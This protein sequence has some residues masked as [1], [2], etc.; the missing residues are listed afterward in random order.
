MATAA[1]PDF[2][3]LQEELRQ[4]RADLSKISE[5]LGGLARHGAADAAGKAQASIHAA[6]DHVKSQANGVA[7]AIQEKPVASAV[8]AF[9]IGIVLGILCAGRRA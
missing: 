5:T 7:D 1:T 2:T 8:T 4:L 3:T 6:V 9:G